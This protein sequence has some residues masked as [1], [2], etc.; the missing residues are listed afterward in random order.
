M[1]PRWMSLLLGAV[2]AVLVAV[3]LAPYIPAPG[4]QIVAVIA[5]IAAAVLA[6]L[7][8]LALVRGDGARL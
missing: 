8:V 6:I 4:A 3:L 5:Y 2:V 7:G 1:L